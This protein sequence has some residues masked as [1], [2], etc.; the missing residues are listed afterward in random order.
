MTTP[1]YIDNLRCPLCGHAVYW[2]CHYSGSAHCSQGEHV[3]RLGLNSPTCK[4]GGTGLQ[5]VSNHVL[6]DLST[7]LLWR[8][9]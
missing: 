4:W 5:R 7:G 2:T 9:S 6:C 1:D 8:T 3:T